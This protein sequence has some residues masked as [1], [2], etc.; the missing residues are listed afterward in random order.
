MKDFT[1]RPL[2]F[3]RENMKMKETQKLLEEF[4]RQSHG[5]GSVLLACTSG[6]FGE[7]LDFPGNELLGAVIVGIPLAEMNVEVKALVNYYQER[8]G[9]GWE[10]GYT[11]PAMQKAIQASGRVIRTPTDQGIVVLLDSRY[12]WEN[13]QKC[14]PPTQKFMVGQNPAELVKQFWHAKQNNK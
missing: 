7:G 11:F 12:A 3:Q 1:M 13:Y 14:L 6:S 8:F 5:F 4:K 10:Y 9:K 2:L